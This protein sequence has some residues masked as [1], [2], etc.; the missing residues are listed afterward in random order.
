MK[1]TNRSIAPRRAPKNKSRGR[2]ECSLR[3]VGAPTQGQKYLPRRSQGVVVLWASMG[4]PKRSLESA[5]SAPMLL[6]SHNEHAMWRSKP[7]PATWNSVSG[8]GTA[9]MTPNG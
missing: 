2:N 8:S 7:K 9:L 1:P 4:R 6:R 3:S 5:V